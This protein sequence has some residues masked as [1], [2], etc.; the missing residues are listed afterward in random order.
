MIVLW[1]VVKQL[2]IALGFMGY[3]VG[4]YLL[5]AWFRDTFGIGGLI[6]WGFGFFLVT[7][8]VYLYLDARDRRRRE[9]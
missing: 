5:A 8:A 4:N 6:G 2:L 7:G 9:Y 3:M 1:E